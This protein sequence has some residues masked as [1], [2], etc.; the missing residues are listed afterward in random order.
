[1]FLDRVWLWYGI[2][3][4]WADTVSTSELRSYMEGKI[5]SHTV[6]NNPLWALMAELTPQAIDIILLTNNLRKLADDVNRE[7]TKWFRDDWSLHSI[8]I[9]ATDFFLGNDLI[10]VA[11][12]ELTR[13]R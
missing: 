8:N 7:L 5:N 12:E 2:N 4:Y 13:N 6:G 10:N 9:V 1:M 11:V 3:Q